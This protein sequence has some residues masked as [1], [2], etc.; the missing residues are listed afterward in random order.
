MM[1]SVLRF[2]FLACL[3]GVAACGPKTLHDSFG[4]R[5]NAMFGTQAAERASQPPTA[6]RGEEVQRVVQKYYQTIEPSEGGGGS[7]QASG[8]VMALPRPGASAGSG[9]G[10]SLRGR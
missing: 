5:Y 4:M 9:G 2:S 3:G 1:R 8:P 6:M 7:Q 10:I